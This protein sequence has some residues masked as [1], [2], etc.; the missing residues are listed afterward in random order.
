MFKDEYLQLGE[1]GGRTAATKFHAE[2]EEYV[3]GS[4]PGVISPKIITRMYVNVKGLS[5]LCVRGGLTTEPSLI[6]D[7]VR[8]FNGSFPQFDLIDIGEGKDSAHDKIGGT[9]RSCPRYP[10]ERS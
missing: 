8:G 5:E 10:P 9:Q 3:A 4:F 7:F 1:Q 2:L 6:D